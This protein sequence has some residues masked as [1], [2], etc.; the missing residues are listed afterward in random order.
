MA[1]VYKSMDRKLKELFQKATYSPESNL[2]EDIF[3]AISIKEKRNSNIKL[4]VYSILGI[5]SFSGFFVILKQLI[6]DFY[7]SG[8]YDYLSLLFNNSKAFSYWKEISLSIVESLPMT[9]LIL[10]L[11]FV[12]I[13]I[14]SLRCMARN[15]RIS[16]KLLI[17]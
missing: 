3:I 11:S 12:F 4:L 10:S 7:N 13:F 6:S 5:F 1:L 2:S 17:A 16:P 9:N 15:I 8:L 14:L